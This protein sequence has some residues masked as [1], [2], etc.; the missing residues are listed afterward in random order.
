MMIP[1]SLYIHIPFCR[2][3]CAYCD[4]FSA[5]AS[6]DEQ[7]AYVAALLDEIANEAPAYCDHEV[8]TVFIGGGS[9]SVL[10]VEDIEMIMARLREH[11]RFATTAGLPEISIEVN[12]GT[13]TGDILSR[14]HAVGINRLSIGLQSTVDTELRLLG[15]GHSYEDFLAAYHGA[16]KS[17][18]NNINIDLIHAL[19]GQTLG[20]WEENLGR[21]AALSPE[22]ISAYGLS[23][24]TGT[25]FYERFGPGK[26]EAGKMPDEELDRRMYQHTADFLDAKN[27]IRYEI[28]N[29]A[30]PGHECKHNLC[31]WRRGDY[32][33]L[34]LGAASMIN[35]VRW[36]NSRSLPIVKENIQQL[37]VD[38][39]MEEYIFL[40]LRL[41]EGVELDAFRQNF[42]RDILD[43]HAPLLDEL[44]SAGLIHMDD[45][46]RLSKKGIDISNYVC[47]RF[48]M[49]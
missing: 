19:P 1:L 32:L 11:Y 20:D 41:G 35:N 33:G 47:A 15:R 30:R 39:Q 9:P 2:S 5:P 7:A 23:I 40:G 38:V 25:P 48:I 18:F 26:P 45:S 13:V 37:S 36:S 27:F 42:G 24:E 17:G 12:P 31:Y 4:F 46:L 14:Y 28:S 44:C 29:H 49:T 6:R 10:P 3:K 16:R 22:H 34:G 8:Q 21:V 43:I